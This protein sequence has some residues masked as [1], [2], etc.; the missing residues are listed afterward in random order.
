[1]KEKNPRVGHINF[2][3]CLPL[4]YSFSGEFGKDLEINADVPSKLNQDI[5]NNRLDVSPVSSIVYARNSDK[6]V[7]MPDVSINADGIVQSI[8]LVSKKPIEQLTDDKIVLTAKSATSH[9]LLKIVLHKAYH[10]TPRY[11]IQSIDMQKIIPDAATATL[12]IGDDALYAN[13]HHEEHLYYY[14]IGHEWK[15][16]TGLK[17][18]YAVWVINKTFAEK[19]QALV[20]KVYEQVIKGFKYGYKH[21]AKAIETVLEQKPFS[22]EQLNDYLEV[23]KWDFADEHRQALLKFYELSYEMGLIEAMPEIKMAEVIRC[24]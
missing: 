12:L 9:C 15:K 24:D 10:A 17:M 18:V 8:I 5:V 19:N 11:E 21:K 22:V 3:N 2:L 23:I 6:L 4:T 20:Q 16:M 7:I 13:H 14:D 1:M